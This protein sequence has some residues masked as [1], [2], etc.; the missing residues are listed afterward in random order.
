MKSTLLIALFSL[1]AAPFARADLTVYT[2]RPTDRYKLVA[3]RLLAQTGEKLVV[4][5][6]A[7]GELVKRLQSE[8]ANSPADVLMTKDIVYLTDAVQKNLLQPMRA[9]PAVSKVRAQMREP[10]NLWVAHTF[11]ARTMA[12]DPSRVNAAEINSYEDLADEKWAGRLC[13]RS[14]AAAYNEALVAF[15]ISKHGYA[16]AKG[17]VQGWVENLGASVFKDDTS[18]LQAITSGLCEI[19]IVNHYYLAGLVAQNPNF[20]VKI[21]FLEQNGGGVHTNGTGLGIVRSS[22]KQ[23]LA[24]K[25]ID[26]MLTEEVQLQTSSAHMDYPAVQGILPGTLIRNWGQFKADTTNWAGVGKFLPEARKLI[27][28][29][30]YN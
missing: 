9:T 20:P 2:D 22:K 12:Y 25:F 21:K 13:M 23:E 14:G 6:A 3:E 24:Q 26:L 17:I 4:V 5:E 27:K 29:V 19:G 16:K 1:L 7:Y 28:E 11:R 8:G 30:G 18:L 10:S 15:M